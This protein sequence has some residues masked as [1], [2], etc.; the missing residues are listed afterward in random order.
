M[1]RRADIAPQWAALCP[2]VGPL[3]FWK[4]LF[5]YRGGERERSCLLGDSHQCSPSTVYP[6]SLHP[7]WVW[8]DKSWDVCQGCSSTF[9]HNSLQS[10]NAFL[11]AIELRA[12]GY[13]SVERVL[14]QSAG[15][16]GT[17]PHA[18]GKASV[19]TQTVTTALRKLRQ[20][21]QGFKTSQ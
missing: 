9:G 20:E 21:G 14:V 19:L 3:L 13:S 7:C 16:P 15:S 8:G 10:K 11:N 2:F 18:L 4:I 1:E 17:G 12:P 5:C 6:L